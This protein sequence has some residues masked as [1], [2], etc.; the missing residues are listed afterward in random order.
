MT[1][2]P[3][4]IRVVSGSLEILWQDGACD[5][6]S[7]SGLRRHCQCAEC[8]SATIR[9]ASIEPSESI[10]IT[11]VVPIGNYAIQI[12]FSDGHSRGI[13]PFSYLRD[14]HRILLNNTSGS[15]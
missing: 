3:Q 1:I 14:L 5:R 2:Q 15:L 10:V 4:D 6:Y 12:F 7:F 11:D 8:R 13:Y 9:G